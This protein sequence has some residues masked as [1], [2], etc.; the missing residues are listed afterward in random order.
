[1]PKK[2]NVRLHGLCLLSFTFFV[3]LSLQRRWSFMDTCCAHSKHFYYMQQN[4]KKKNEYDEMYSNKSNAQTTTSRVVDAVLK[5]RKLFNCIMQIQLL[6]SVQCPS[7]TFVSVRSLIL[8]VHTPNC[9]QKKKPDAYQN[10]ITE[11]SF[12][13]C[14]IFSFWFYSSCSKF[15]LFRKMNYLTKKNVFSCILLYMKN[16]IRVSRNFLAFQFFMT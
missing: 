6:I 11:K 2:V 15:F 10:R 5:V 7:K 12:R 8:K 9:T 1:M 16:L 14:N 3:H 13:K 4:N